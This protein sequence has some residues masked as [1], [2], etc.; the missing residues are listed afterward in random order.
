MNFDTSNLVKS[1]MVSQH[2]PSTHQA[3]KHFNMQTVQ[4][5]EQQKLTWQE[6]APQSD[7]PAQM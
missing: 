4:T 6:E 1:Q 5:S 3:S 7:F 2:K